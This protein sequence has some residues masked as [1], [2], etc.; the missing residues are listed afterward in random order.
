MTTLFSP[1]LRGVVDDLLSGDAQKS[2]AAGDRAR[3]LHLDDAEA[4]ALFEIA[5]GP[6]MP[7]PAPFRDSAA[8]LLMVLWSS[9]R[10]ALA[11]AVLGRYAALRDG[12]RV[13]LLAL[14]GAIGTRAS[15]QALAALVAQHGFPESC[16]PRV[17][18]ELFNLVEHADLLFPSL[19][20]RAG[21]YELDVG[22][23][24]LAALERKTLAP[25][26]LAQ[27]APS[28]GD[29]LAHAIA[30][31]GPFQR[32]DG[33]AWRFDEAY[34]PARARAAFLADLAGWLPS[35]HTTSTLG[36]ALRLADPWIRTFAAISLLRVSEPVTDPDLLALAACHETRTILFDQLHRLGLLARYPR[37][38]ADLDAFAAADM[39][40]WL[41][42]PTELGREPDALEKMAT[43]VS[44]DPASPFVLYL[45]RFRGRDGT[46]LASLSGPY[47]RHAAPGPVSGSAT[48]S[49]FT[50]WDALGAEVHASAILKNLADWRLDW[51]RRADQLPAAT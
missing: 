1:A 27:L 16:Y 13:P 12:L 30:E 35:A 9:P 40:A 3:G 46:W 36:A 29:A 7:A 45:W 23:V 28:L 18:R 49:R 37:A 5:T 11:A 8:D 17:F 19:F 31:A 6:T 24:L 44:A 25:A 2:L 41:K 47:P 48:F 15:A 26:T 51:Q 10:E 33:I 38:F 20:E 22:D 42:Y 43:F 50:P 21:P 32:S 34:A 4:L 39:V 14:L